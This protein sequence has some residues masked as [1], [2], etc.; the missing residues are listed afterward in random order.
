LLYLGNDK[1]IKLS[2]HIVSVDKREQKRAGAG[3]PILLYS[4]FYTPLWQPR[5]IRKLWGFF[6]VTNAHFKENPIDFFQTK[7]MTNVLTYRAGETKCD[8][9]CTV[10]FKNR[11]TPLN[12]FSTRKIFCTAGIQTLD[13]GTQKFR[14]NFFES[15]RKLC[16]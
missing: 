12:I 5:L 14:H 4:S 16:K 10:S 3:F 1:P 9:Q 15:S 8:G 2:Y 7:T 11:H 13:Y 6:C